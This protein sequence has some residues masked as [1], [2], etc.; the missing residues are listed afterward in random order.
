MDNEEK[1][2]PVELLS[3]GPEDILDPP[4]VVLGGVQDLTPDLNNIKTRKA[5][6]ILLG[7]GHTVR[8]TITELAIMCGGHQFSE[9]S[10]LSLYM[11]YSEDIEEF[12]RQYAE[13][14]MSAGLVR[15]EIRLT[16]LSQLAEDWEDGARTNPKAAMIYLKALDQ[17]HGETKDLDIPVLN[18][19]DKWFSLLQ[20]LQNLRVSPQL[21]ADTM[22][23]P[24]ENKSNSNSKPTELPN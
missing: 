3:V 11:Q 2:T 7:K 22:T 1:K 13:I 23:D 9:M 18:P 6:I 5:V 19:E 12:R 17:I 16:R 8:K 4:G 24:I 10:I 14:V 15:K 21:E 20:S